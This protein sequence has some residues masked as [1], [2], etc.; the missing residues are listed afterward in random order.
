MTTES[1]P[2]RSQLIQDTG[3]AIGVTERSTHSVPYDNQLQLKIAE[4]CL[5]KNEDGTP[6]HTSLNSISGELDRQSG[7]VW[8]TW[9]RLISSLTEKIENP[10]SQN[11]RLQKIVDA[12][13]KV[14]GQE[15]IT[16]AE[17]LKSLTDFKERQQAII[18]ARSISR[19][20][21]GSEERQ[22][23]IKEEAVQTR[24]AKIMLSLT[25]TNPDGSK[26]HS[27]LDG[28]A[29]E[30]YPDVLNGL[31]GEE[32]KEKI[33]V[34]KKAIRTARQDFIADL[35]VIKSGGP[36]SK[37]VASSQVILKIII[38]VHPGMYDATD[39]IDKLTADLEA[40]RTTRQNFWKRKVLMTYAQRGAAG[41]SHMHATHT[42]VAV[43]A[44]SEELAGI[45][46]PAELNK[47]T[48]KR[49]IRA[50]EIARMFVAD[51]TD[52]STNPTSIAIFDE[53]QQ[54][55]P[56]KSKWQILDF[57]I[58]SDGRL[59]PSSRRKTFNRPKPLRK[60]NPE[61]APKPVVI[62]PIANIP[63]EPFIFGKPEAAEPP[64]EITR[65][66]NV[67]DTFDSSA[68]TVRG[69]RRG[70][71]PPRERLDADADDHFSQ[72]LR[73]SRGYNKKP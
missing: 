21:Q 41:S 32:F 69:G 9:Q 27:D 37:R 50:A 43:A 40:V 61:T 55:F 28:A 29:Q 39:E 14:P 10:Q 16:Q 47:E 33:R 30:A 11:P 17:L 20:Q 53:L 4:A 59:I 31:S 26:K 49:T 24:K 12:L 72:A 25:A 56:D 44:S 7:N 67:K 15:R 64:I 6:R 71:V 65:V 1:N 38:E 62:A 19:Q 51:I 42:D 36:V 70:S 54:L 73:R 45:T 58:R 68:R 46:D 13:R 23:R 3:R 2:G 60:K 22:A 34:L 57:F 48:R 66:T 18:M 5:A 8:R 63:S 35:L 52:A